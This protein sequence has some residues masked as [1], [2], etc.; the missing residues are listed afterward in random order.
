MK[1]IL[2]I[3]ALSIFM[4]SACHPTLRVTEKSSQDYRDIKISKKIII[5]DN[6]TYAISK[7]GV[8]MMIDLNLYSVETLSPFS[9]THRF[10]DHVQSDSVV[11]LKESLSYQR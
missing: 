2:Y 8:P 11:N 3:A 4:L 1:K 7:T 9:K 6:H 10:F 5:Q